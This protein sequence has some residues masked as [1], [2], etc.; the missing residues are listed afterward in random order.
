[1][2]DMLKDPFKSQRLPSTSK[3]A[4]DDWIKR[5]PVGNQLPRGKYFKCKLV[6]PKHQSEE[7]ELQ[8]KPSR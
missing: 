4:F 6:V 7:T 2:V 1:M 5:V 8:F 3:P